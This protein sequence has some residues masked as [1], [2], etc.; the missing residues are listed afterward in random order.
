MLWKE[1]LA[2]FSAEFRRHS[3]GSV[4]T[5]ISHLL[6]LSAGSFFTVEAITGSNINVLSTWLAGNARET[7][8]I[9]TQTAQWRVQTQL[10]VE[11]S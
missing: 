9:E 6:S 10:Q 7:Q 2:T 8:T 4:Y 11:F 5:P 3:G 1:T